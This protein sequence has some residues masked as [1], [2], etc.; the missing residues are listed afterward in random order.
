MNVEQ[1]YRVKDEYIDRWYN[2]YNS[3]EEIEAQQEKGYHA[4]DIKWYAMNWGCS[5][6]DLM[7][8]LE[9]IY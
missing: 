9:E 4:E 8:Q 7:E 1:R 6:D 2:C 5:V 3:V